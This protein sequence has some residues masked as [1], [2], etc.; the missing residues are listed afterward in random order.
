MVLSTSIMDKT[1]KIFVR[2]KISPKV[3]KRGMRGGVL[4]KYMYLWPDLGNLSREIPV[5]NFQ[6]IK[7]IFF[8]GLGDG[9]N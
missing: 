5:F 1:P 8:K 3:I 7:W 9:S 6:G 4:H 2:R